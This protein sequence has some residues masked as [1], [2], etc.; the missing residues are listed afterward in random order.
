M[1]RAEAQ[2]TITISG[3]DKYNS[4]TVKV[5]VTKADVTLHDFKVDKNTYEVAPGKT[6]KI[7]VTDAP[8]DIKFESA[9]KSYATVDASGTITGVKAG[10]TTIKISAKDYKDLSVTVKI[11]EGQTMELSATKVTL[12][13]GGTTKLTV[14]GPSAVTFKSSKDAVAKNLF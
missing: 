6:V 13:V 4:A 2:G 12:K 3:G 14:K 1:A 11:A 9:D 7:T 5:T 8:S 10:T